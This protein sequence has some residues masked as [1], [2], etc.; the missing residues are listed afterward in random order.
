MIY[1]ILT[2][3]RF[4]IDYLGILKVIICIPFIIFAFEKP[5]TNMKFKI[6][7]KYITI[8]TLETFGIY[9]GVVL[10]ILYFLGTKEPL[11]FIGESFSATILIYFVIIYPRKIIGRDGYIS[12]VKNGD[13]V[14]T[15][16]DLDEIISVESRFKRYNTVVIRTRSG[17]EY[18]LHPQDPQE[19]ISYL[20]KYH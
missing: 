18:V 10:F 7:K 13:Y 2:Y 1:I 11:E 15:I 3:D 20:G 4:E 9:V 17:N 6:D 16:I 14:R 8:R 19:L 12:F 5:N